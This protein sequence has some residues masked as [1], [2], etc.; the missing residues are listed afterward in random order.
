[1]LTLK[2]SFRKSPLIH[3]TGPVASKSLK[4]CWC[5]GL[6]HLNLPPLNC[7]CDL[8]SGNGGTAGRTTT[9][10]ACAWPEPCPS[11]RPPPGSASTASN[12]P[13]PCEQ[14]RHLS[15]DLIFLSKPEWFVYTRSLRIPTGTCAL[16]QVAATKQ[17][18]I[19]TGEGRLLMDLIW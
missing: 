11:L 3:S 8:P 13:Q 5:Y 9:A 6:C 7:R 15:E 10:S 18:E 1:M 17:S 14:G 19:H 2:D 12:R 16:W 4:C